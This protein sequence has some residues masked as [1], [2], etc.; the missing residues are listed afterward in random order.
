VNKSKKSELINNYIFKS[1][2]KLNALF[3]LNIIF[4][5]YNKNNIYGDWGLGIGDWGLGIGP[6]PQ[7]PIPIPNP[8]S[9]N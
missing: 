6:N 9:P 5:K 4:Y 7:S 3:N 2:I 8:Q 1:L